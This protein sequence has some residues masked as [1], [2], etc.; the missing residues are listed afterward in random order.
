MNYDLISVQT[1]G[2]SSEGEGG[3]KVVIRYEGHIKGT[4]ER[5]GSKVYF[6]SLLCGG[7]LFVLT[8][9]ALFGFELFFKRYPL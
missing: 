2:T 1:T 5:D 7:G 6:T 9:Y 4:R 8:H 3:V